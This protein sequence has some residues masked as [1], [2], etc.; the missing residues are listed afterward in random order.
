[1][2]NKVFEKQKK[3]LDRIREEAIRV[4]SDSDAM[5]LKDI[6]ALSERCLKEGKRFAFFYET[7]SLV[8]TQSG[9]FERAEED[10]VDEDNTGFWLF[11]NPHKN[12]EFQGNFEETEASASSFTYFLQ[13]I[14]ATLHQSFGILQRECS[15]MFEDLHE[16][17]DGLEDEEG[18]PSEDDKIV[19]F[20]LDKF[21]K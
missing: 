11:F 14:N 1:M 21:L 15:K 16:L 20:D 17:T 2:D 5:Y 12:S 19:P 9:G 10:S 7:D 3:E 6:K 18:D 13:M 8:P 4:A